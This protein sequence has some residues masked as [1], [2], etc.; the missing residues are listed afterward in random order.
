MQMLERVPN[1]QHEDWLALLRDRTVASRRSQ[2]IHLLRRAGDLTPTELT[3][4]LPEWSDW[5]QLRLAPH[6]TTETRAVL[7]E[8]GR[9]KRIRHSAVTLRNR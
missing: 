8:H 2:E 4:G 1:E 9:T 5:L 3:A 7:A 6:L